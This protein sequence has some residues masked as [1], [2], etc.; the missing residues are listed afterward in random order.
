MQN[1]NSALLQQHTSMLHEYSHYVRSFSVLGDYAMP[2]HVLN[3]YHLIVHIIKR[4]A[5]ELVSRYNGPS[6][7]K[8]AAII[9]GLENGIVRR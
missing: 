9:P 5:I 1:L 3:P 8:I 7:S 2:V 6:A 4:A